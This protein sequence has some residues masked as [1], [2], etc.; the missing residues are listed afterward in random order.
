MNLKLVN[1]CS[2]VLAIDPTELGPE[3]NASNVDVWDSLKHWEIIAAIEMTFGIEFSMDEA[4][5]FKN[6][7][8]IDEFLKSKG[9]G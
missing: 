3:S 4:A 2:E 5:S 7:G 6:L 1:I 9:L 8:D